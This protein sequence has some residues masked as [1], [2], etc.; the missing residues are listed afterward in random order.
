M[1]TE[2]RGRETGRRRNER[3]RGHGLGKEGGQHVLVFGSGGGCVSYRSEGGK[4]GSG[5]RL[6]EWMARSHLER[7]RAELPVD[8]HMEMWVWWSGI[9]ALA[10]SHEH[11][12]CWDWIG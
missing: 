12:A 11:K 4:V 9:W 5:V 10:G 2:I 7:V 1:V 6:G 8:S 3:S